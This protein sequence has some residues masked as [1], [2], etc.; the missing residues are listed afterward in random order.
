MDTTIISSVKSN[1][2]KVMIG[3]ENTISLLL[4]SLLAGGHVLLQDVPGTGKTMLAKTLARSMD[5]QFGRIQF[6][7]DLLPTDVVGL[8]R[9]DTRSGD[10]VFAKGPAFCNVLLADEI[11]R[12]TPKTQSSLL[13]CMA[14]QQITVDGVTYPLE[15]PFFVIATQNSLESLGTFPLPEAQ[16]DR[17]LMQLPMEELDQE[18]E[19]ALLDRFMKDEPLER[20]EP[21]CTKQDIMALQARCRE[22][23]VHEELQDYMVRLVHATRH[24]R[25]IVSGVSPRGTLAFVRAAQGCAMTAGRDYVTPEDIKMVAI[26]VLAH[27]MTMNA[28]YNAQSDAASAMEEILS[29]LPLPTEDW[30]MR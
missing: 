19:L 3:N 28:A 8:N 1:I 13:E 9:L 21:V 30:S 25:R 7:P 15:Q 2:K 29:S 6:T 4:A 14:E 23:Y 20:I 26:P 22:V 11:N 17:F 5:A 16:L 27:R 10:F 18:K 24:N 12:A